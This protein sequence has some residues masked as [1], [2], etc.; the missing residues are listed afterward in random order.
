[1]RTRTQGENEPIRDF[2]FC[3]RA[4]CKRWKSNLT[5]SEIVKMILKIIKAHLASQL[6]SRVFTVDVLVKLGHQ[7]EKD[8]EQQQ[9]Y[10]SSLPHIQQSVLPRASLNR[11]LDKA[12]VQCW[13]CKGHHSPGNCP[14]FTSSFNQSF[15][16]MQ[17]SQSK[18]YQSHPP[19]HNYAGLPT[20]N[21]VSAIKNAFPFKKKHATNSI[22][23]AVLQQL[24]IPINIG[25]WKGKAIID[26]AAS[27]TLLHE[28][29]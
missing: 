26:T 3:Y 20:N 17:P 12:S 4:L 27:Y 7:I 28:S 19:N 8:Y 14:R 18:R 15:P 1:M 16:Q 22:Q 10:E 23:G 6:R 21:A 13:C 2:A 5:E 9:R 29:L 24:V 25:A 11:Q